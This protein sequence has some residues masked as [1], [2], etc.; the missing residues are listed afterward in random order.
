MDKEEIT[1]FIEYQFMRLGMFYSAE[2]EVRKFYLSQIDN[3]ARSKWWLL[4]N[5]VRYVE[6]KHKEY[7]SWCDW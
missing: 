5:V 6:E 4:C 3:P 1:R 7:Y 2:S